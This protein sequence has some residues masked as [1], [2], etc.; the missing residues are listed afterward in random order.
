MLCGLRLHSMSAIV[1]RGRTPPIANRAPYYAHRFPSPDGPRVLMYHVDAPFRI[2][3]RATPGQSLIHRT[4]NRDL[5]LI[6]PTANRDLS[7]PHRLTNLGQLRVRRI[8]NCD[9]SHSHQ[10]ANVR[11]LRALLFANRGLSCAR[12]YR[13]LCRPCP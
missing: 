12:H 11:W 3:P 9:L 7:R 8:S 6:R 4:A 10:N 2:H 1:F 13:D 5:W